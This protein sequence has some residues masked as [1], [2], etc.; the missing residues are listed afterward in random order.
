MGICDSC[1]PKVK[2]AC[3]PSN[4]KILTKKE[5]DKL[6]EYE[7]ALCKINFQTIKDGKVVNAIGTGFF[8]EINDDSIPF[9]KALFTNNHVLNEMNIENNKDIK[10]DYFN[11]PRTIKLTE[12]RKKFTNKKYDYTCIEIFDSDKIKNFFKIDLKTLENKN[13]LKNKEI[14]IL[15]YPNGELSHS[16]G[17]I[18][19][20]YN[21]TIEHNVNTLISSSG[22]PLIERYE[23]NSIIGIHCELKNENDEKVK[24]ATPLD[25]IIKDIKDKLN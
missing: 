9:K 7:S 16:L 10:F 11:K 15:Q 2:Q 5:I 17:I 1:N 18:T 4:A 19:D 20:Y 3:F 24:V 22:A 25:I 6:Y 8:C 14:F 12:N 13:D 21:N 23:I